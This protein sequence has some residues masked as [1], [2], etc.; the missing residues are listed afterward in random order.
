[1]VTTTDGQSESIV[2]IAGAEYGSQLLGVN[3]VTGETIA[4]ADGLGPVI[5]YTAPIAAKGR[6][7]VAGTDWL[8][9]FGVK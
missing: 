5:R 7:Y 8:Y 4:L 3:G 2:W 9:V 6:I 1:M